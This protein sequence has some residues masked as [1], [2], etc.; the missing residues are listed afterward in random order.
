MVLELSLTG[1]DRWEMYHRLQDLD[2]PCSCQAHRPLQVHCRSTLDAIQCW[3]I[4]RQLTQPRLVLAQVLDA[5][6][7]LQTQSSK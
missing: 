7:D 2:I 5:C 6:L 3:S 1:S 4:A